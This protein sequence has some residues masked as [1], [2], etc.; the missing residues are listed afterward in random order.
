MLIW[1]PPS[2]GKT[3][4]SFGPI[5]DHSALLFPELAGARREVMDSLCALGAGAGA[6][7]VLG[8]GKKSASDAALNLALETAPC[9][10]AIEIYTGVLYDNLDAA[11]LCADARGRLNEGT[12]ISSALF[13]FVRPSDRIPTHRLAMGVALP[14]LGSMSAWWRPRLAATLPT[15][16][17]VTI[18]DCRSGAYRT[19]FPAAAANV[20]EIAV[21]EE[22]AAGRKVITHMAKKWR[23]LAVRHLVEDRSLDDH[24]NATDVVASLSRLTSRPEILALEVTEPRG[25]RAGGTITTLTLVTASTE[26]HLRAE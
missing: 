1:L 8:L 11:T 26:P 12:W 13:G 10:P 16:A 7:A 2:E 5:L 25:T 18:V 24:A 22:R 19:A 6:A 14:P 15:L 9:A 21:V 3:A 23:G 4:P 17:G 20:L